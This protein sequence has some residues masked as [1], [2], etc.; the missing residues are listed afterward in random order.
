VADHGSDR[1]GLEQSQESA[2]APADAGALDAIDDDPDAEPAHLVRFGAQVKAKGVDPGSADVERTI[3]YITRYVTKSAADCHTTTSD[4][5]QR[6]H[7][8][9]LWHELRVTPCSERCA[10]WLLYGVQPKKA[11]GRGRLADRDRYARE[12][13]LRWDQRRLDAFIAYVTAAKMV[14][15]AANGVLSQRLSGAPED[16]LADRI[17][18]LAKLEMRRTE[19]FEAFRCLPTASRSKPLTC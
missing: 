9:R 7:L 11:H 19:A 15:A 18:E 10:N 6:D 2:G 17:E 3:G 14:G 1:H 12:L 5:P 13:R 4:D 16:R 8:D